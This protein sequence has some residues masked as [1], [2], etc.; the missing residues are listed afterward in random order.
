MYIFASEKLNLLLH[1]PWVVV[2]RFESSLFIRLFIL[3]SVCYNGES[4]PVPLS[5]STAEYAV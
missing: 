5:Y 2:P 1:V 3:L 4:I